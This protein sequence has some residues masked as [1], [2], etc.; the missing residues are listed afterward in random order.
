MT[1]Q[2]DFQ[3]R[4]NACLDRLQHGATVEECLALYAQDAAELEPLL[5]TARLAMSATAAARPDARAELLARLS[6]SWNEHQTRPARR[7][8]FL[9]PVFSPALRAGAV[10]L[11]AVFALV[12]GG[13]STTS[14]ATDS[15]PGEVLYPV[16]RTHER[17]LLLIV[18][19]SDERARLHARLVERRGAEM[20]ALAHA[21]RN[22]PELEQVSRRLEGHVQSAVVLVGGPQ[23]VQVAVGEPQRAPPQPPRVLVTGPLLRGDLA[24]RELHALFLR[25]ME[26]HQRMLQS[27]LSDMPEP[28]RQRFQPAFQRSHLQLLHALAIL[29]QLA[30][31]R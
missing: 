30:A 16:K 28:R 18:R 31:E 2:R 19:P 4:L 1:A 14:A 21:D 13:W 12:A 9:P 26:A 11:V 7:F 10:A 3:E 29:E 24:R 6:Q 8:S 25:Q 5:R 23:L 15:V 27:V 17:F 22:G 20:A